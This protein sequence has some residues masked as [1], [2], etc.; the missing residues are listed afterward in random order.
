M[1]AADNNLPRQLP[2]YL[3]R[4]SSKG[5]RDDSS[6]DSILCHDFPGLLAE[7]SS[8]RMREENRK[9]SKLEKYTEQAKLHQW[10]HYIKINISQSQSF[11]SSSEPHK[12][13][14]ERKTLYTSVFHQLLA[15]SSHN[16][17]SFHY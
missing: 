12:I 3:V 5:E 8:V 6:S 14:T 10:H 13:A 15:D 1:T 16:Y 11:I 9:A 2:S 4:L 7:G 17:F